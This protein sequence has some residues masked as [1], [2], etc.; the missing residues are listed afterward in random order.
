MGLVVFSCFLPSAHCISH[1]S[2]QDTGHLLA[3]FT[4]RQG[5]SLGSY[6][7]ANSLVAVKNYIA[8]SAATVATR[9]RDV[10]P[11]FLT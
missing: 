1:D 2:R 5:N 9:L 10:S 8:R 3:L 6:K 7:I 4:S 11:N